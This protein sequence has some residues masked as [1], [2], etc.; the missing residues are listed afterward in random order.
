[1]AWLIA[2]PLV[3]LVAPITRRIVQRLVSSSVEAGT[4]AS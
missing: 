1:M 2:F 4:E 3:L